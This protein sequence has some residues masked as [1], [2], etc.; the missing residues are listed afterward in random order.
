MEYIERVESTIKALRQKKM[1]I[2]TDD[3]GRENEADLIFP[4]EL[5]TAEQMNFLIRHTS[6]IICLALTDTQ[7]ARLNLPLMVS[8][9]EN[10]SARG[11]PF[12]ISIDAKNGITTG[13]S[14]SDRAK[15][16][17]AAIDDT[18][19][20]QDIVRPGHIFPLKAHSGG[21][22]VRAGHTEGSIDIVRLAGFKSAAVL[23]EI[24]NPDGTM[25]RGNQLKAFAKQHQLPILSIEDLIHYR[26]YFENLI[27]EETSATLPTELHG[28]F[29]ITVIRE[30]F[31][32]SEHLFLTNEK[33]STNHP[34]LVRIHSSC[35]TGDLF[36]SRRCDC[37]QQLHFALQ[38]ISK[39][40]GVLIY[41][42][43]EG[44]GLGLFNKIKSYALQE[45]GLDTIEAND[46]LQLPADN[47]KY[48]IAANVLRNMH[49]NHI[50]LMTN[51]PAKI[52]GLKNFGIKEIELYAM[53]IFYNEQNKNYLLAKKNKLNHLINCDF[54]SAS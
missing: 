15:T 36:T 14:A 28:S 34:P 23:C 26:Q 38:Q 32:G 21:V 1:L 40:G 49:I 42:N 35:I 33:Y 11:T 46:L 54:L 47:R 39:E 50:R 9:Y 18:A 12:T 10:N 25:T 27:E 5:A 3:V 6:G 52:N 4:A 17:L 22:L 29:K 2:L 19:T 24:M 41:L 20:Q 31:T 43:Q 44:R 13:V 51:N 7:L 8:T 45:Q 53:P 16:V 30:K 37:N 48:H